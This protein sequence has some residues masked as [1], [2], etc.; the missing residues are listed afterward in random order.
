M[1]KYRIIPQP[2]V[3]SNM[4]FALETDEYFFCRLSSG[5]VNADTDLALI[6][7][8]R[9]DGCCTAE[10]PAFGGL[11]RMCYKLTHHMRT[12]EH[13]RSCLGRAKQDLAH[14]ISLAIPHGN[15]EPY[16]NRYQAMF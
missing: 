11:A 3:H 1:S 14:C 2:E 10:H 6:R 13:A 9:L 12:I 7:N 5:L 15:A 16:G 4:L 8:L